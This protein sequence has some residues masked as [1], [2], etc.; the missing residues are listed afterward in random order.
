MRGP[1]A[2]GL[3]ALLALSGCTPVSRSAPASSCLSQVAPQALE[4]ITAGLGA[5]SAA[6]VTADDRLWFDDSRSGTLG[7]LNPDG[8][9]TVWA[10]GLH[11]PGSMVEL[12]D[13]SILVAERES[14]DIVHVIPGLG[15]F[16]FRAADRP[17]MGITSMVQAPGDAVFAA[18]PGKILQVSRGHEE[19]VLTGLSNRPGLALEPGGAI[20]ISDRN[21]GLERLDRNGSLGFIPA[22]PPIRTL[23]VDHHGWLIF[24]TDTGELW[25]WMRGT[26]TRLLAGLPA[27]AAIAVDQADNILVVAPRQN[28]VLRLVTSFVLRP[29]VRVRAALGKRVSVCLPIE[30]ASSYTEPVT[31]T[32][33]ATPPGI[34]ATVG[35]QPA[36]TKGATLNLLSDLHERLKQGAV[37]LNL[38]SGSLRQRFFVTLDFGG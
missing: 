34:E 6:L 30:R 29:T 25:R 31:L 17:G 33:A 15:T 9:I 8:S 11:S 12:G 18:V 5:P 38:E 24:V 22:L 21:V 14:G 20:L 3:L 2:T 36:G 1:V 7:R 13:G 19:V 35:Q 10:R 16:L 4:P 37:V 32:V 27:D 26:G 23:T 28:R